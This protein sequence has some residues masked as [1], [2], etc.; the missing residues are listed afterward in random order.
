METINGIE[1]TD[2]TWKG[3]LMETVLPL[4]AI[5]YPEL[6]ETIN[7]RRIEGGLN[8]IEM[9]FYAFMPGITPDEDRSNGQLIDDAAMSV[10]IALRN[11][12]ISLEKRKTIITE[13]KNNAQQAKMLMENKPTEGSV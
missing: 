8:D 7:F 13:F 1:P 6:L 3:Y 2:D 11:R 9:S 10:D 5:N 4:V 12:S